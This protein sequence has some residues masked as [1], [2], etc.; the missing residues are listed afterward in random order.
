M[1]ELCILRNL[2]SVKQD[3]TLLWHFWGIAKCRKDIL[4]WNIHFT[5]FK[6][7]C[8]SYMKTYRLCPITRN[9]LTRLSNGLDFQTL[10]RSLFC[11]SEDERC[12]MN[13][14][15]IWYS[16]QS[17]FSVTCTQKPSPSNFIKNILQRKY[18]KNY[19]KSV[20]EPLFWV[21]L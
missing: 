11:F 2:Y 5:V 9:C 1:H 16:Q 15:D 17:L 14:C 4:D 6:L 18:A 13:V 7:L 3:K 12:F 20:T 21:I 10:K 19:K 8:C